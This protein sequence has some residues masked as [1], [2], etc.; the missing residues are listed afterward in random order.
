M[1]IT[2]ERIEELD[3][4]WN[5]SNLMDGHE[6]WEWYSDLTDEEQELI[7][8]WDKQYENGVLQ[9]CEKILE[10]ESNQPPELTHPDSAQTCEP[11][12]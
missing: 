9:L 3:H 6:Y 4:C 12:L 11:E 8:T 10:Q 7:D 2:Q 1:A 5:E